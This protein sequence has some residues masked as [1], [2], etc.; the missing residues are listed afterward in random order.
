VELVSLFFLLK[1]GIFFCFC[2]GV[3]LRVP[4]FLGVFIRAGLWSFMSGIRLVHPRGLFAGVSRLAFSSSPSFV[5]GTGRIFIYFS[6]IFIL[7]W[8]WGAGRAGEEEGGGASTWRRV[9]ADV[10]AGDVVGGARCR[11]YCFFFSFSNSFSFSV[12]FF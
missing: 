7:G 9:D 3:V 6:F 5:L 4:R 8:F 10:K 2:F 12:L 11:F 1:I